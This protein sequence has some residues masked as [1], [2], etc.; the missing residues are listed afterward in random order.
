LLPVAGLEDLSENDISAKKLIE[1]KIK[2]FSDVNC[3][4]FAFLELL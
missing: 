1:M 4:D 3:E 2:N